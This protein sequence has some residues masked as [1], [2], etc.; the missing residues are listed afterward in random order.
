[1][2]ARVPG[3]IALPDPILAPWVFPIYLV[4][5]ALFVV[6]IALAGQLHL[7]AGVMPDSFVISLPLAEADPP[8]CVL[9]LNVDV[10]TA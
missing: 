10:V 4:L 9:V 5:A 6:P 3:N 8:E 1:L 7:P 2:R